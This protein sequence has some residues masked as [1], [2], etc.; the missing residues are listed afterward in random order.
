MKKGILLLALASLFM[1]AS[2]DKIE[3]DNYQIFAGAAGEW[4][5]GAPVADHS[6]RAY[7]EKYTGVKCN[8]CPKADTAISMTLKKYDGKL[9]AVSIHDSSA[10]CKPYEGQ[11]DM[12]SNDGNTWSTYFGMLTKNKPN[13]MLSRAKSDS[14]WLTFDPKSG[15]DNQ[16]DAEIGTPAKVALA[17]DSKLDNDKIAINVH[18]EYLE[19]VS[20]ELTVTLFLM[21][22]G[23]VAEQSIAG[24]PNDP[25]YV[26]NHILRDVITD[27]WGADIDADGKAGTARRAL[28]NYGEFKSEW[29]LGHCHIVAFVSEKATKKV[30]NVAECEI[31]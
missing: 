17:V 4:F 5:D 1:A 29:N 30:L 11:A 20:D 7:L 18:L 27:I 21:E 14:D 26:H 6:H 16:V 13:A 19:N 9:I 31:D 2:C 28:F 25:N 3:S 23:I 15:F 8:N 24:K 12:R 10:F 22:D